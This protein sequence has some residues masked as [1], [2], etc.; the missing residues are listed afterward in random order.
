MSTVNDKTNNEQPIVAKKR[1]RKSKKEL[2]LAAQQ[3][4]ANGQQPVKAYVIA[5][6]VSSAQEANKK[7]E[8]LSTL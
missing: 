8:N 2:E 7:I 4:N 5:Q 1:G 6:D 3:A